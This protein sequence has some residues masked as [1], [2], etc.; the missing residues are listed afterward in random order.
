LLERGNRQS[1][2]L[3]VARN[4]DHDGF[5]GHAEMIT[6]EEMMPRLVPLA[7]TQAF[8][9]VRTR[10]AESVRHLVTVMVWTG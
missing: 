9:G 10:H 1:G 3:V 7:A 5:A 6:D 8:A 4:H 2:G